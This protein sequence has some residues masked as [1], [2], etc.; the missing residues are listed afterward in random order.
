MNTRPV[1]SKTTS[2]LRLVE[3][4]IQF[5]RELEENQKKQHRN[6]EPQD[7]LVSVPYLPKDCIFNI[8]V[9][10]PLE[11]LM[12]SRFVCKSWYEIVNN[13]TFI[14]AHMRRS[15]IG[16][17][18][19][20]PVTEG[21]PS[22]VVGK[23]S[24]SSAMRINFSVESK[25]SELQSMPVHHWPLIDPPSLF[26]IKYLEIKDGK[27]MIKEYNTTCM[28]QIRATFNGL[29]VLDNCMKRGGLIV[30]NPVTGELKPIPLGTRSSPDHESYG[31]G[32]CHE[33]KRYKLVHLFQD[34]LRYIGCEIMNIESRSWRVVDG[35]PSGLFGRLAYQPIFAIGALHWVPSVDHNEY[36]V[37]MPV[38]VEK[39]EKIPLPNTGGIHDRI[40]EMGG[41]LGF[42]SR[43]HTNQI[44]VWILRSL[45]GEGWEKQY[46]IRT[47][48]CIRN[49]VPL[50]CMGI[51]AELV[52]RS[53]DN[54][55]YAYDHHS[56]LMR[57][58]DVNKENLPFVYR[59]FPHVNSLISWRI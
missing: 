30:L 42:V 10:L 14:Y 44:D 1:V 19:L 53:K 48:D 6:K 43:Q 18:F 33:S 12:T 51:S 4:R 50:Y 36:I 23:T 45:A 31:L 35:P 47:V 32:F 9:R 25:V 49:L 11:S 27:G 20:S 15:D 57:K 37:S 5:K 56:Q 2:L 58:V 54:D 17:I 3:E 13:P 8:I 52:F 38:D 28:G 7:I 41:F 26:Y 39:F 59:Y 21:L 24:V 29:I 16:L 55:L 22:S 34:N 46:S 40:F